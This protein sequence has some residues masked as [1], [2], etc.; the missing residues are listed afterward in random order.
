M[1][2]NNG[3]SGK[4]KK[5]LAFKAK[6]EAGY[7]DSKKRYELIMTLILFAVAAGIFVL[8]LALN[9]WEK[10]QYIH[11]HCGALRDPDG[12]VRDDLYHVFPLSVCDRKRSGRDSRERTP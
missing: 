2:D 8:G 7:I 10:R 9:K 12:Q 11:D 1:A 3:K 4:E 6:G 5:R